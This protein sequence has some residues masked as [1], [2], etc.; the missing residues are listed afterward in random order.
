DVGGYRPGALARARST[1]GADA[2]LFRIEGAGR[3]AARSWRFAGSDSTALGERVERALA[4]RSALLEGLRGEERAT[5]AFRLL[6]GEADGVPGLAVDLL[7]DELRLLLL[8]RAAEPL[9]EEVVATLAARLPMD[10]AAVLVTHLA[11]RPKGELRCVRPL[12]GRPRVEP[13][14]V[15]EAG[16]AFEVENGLREPM[17]SR[18]GIGLFLDQRANRARIARRIRER[19]GGRWLNLFCHTGAFSVVALGAGADRVVSVDLSR[20][21]LETLERNLEHNRL[22]GARHECVRMDAVRFL[23]RLG[24]SERFDGVVLDP[25]TAAAAGRRFWSA[26]KLQSTLIA[27]CLALLSPRGALLVCRNDRSARGELRALVAREAA[28]SRVELAEL[29]E[30]GPAPDFPRLAGFR[31]GDAFEGALAIRRG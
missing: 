6:H 4:K 5:T 21:Y 25:P 11:E 2:G 18:P 30:A 31:E 22:D 29:E 8:G 27:R 7:E 10:P 14:C 9:V 20:P 26:R 16:Y 15:R 1:R 19:G 3:I 13:F 17:V 24:A 23:E 12:R 28:R